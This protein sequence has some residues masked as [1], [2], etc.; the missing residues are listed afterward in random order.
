MVRF[1]MFIFLAISFIRTARIPYCLKDCEVNAI[2][3]KQSR[4]LQLLFTCFNYKESS[5]IA[6]PGY[7]KNNTLMK[8][9]HVT[10]EFKTISGDIYSFRP[11]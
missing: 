9:L 6:V 1:E 5:R 7:K 4:T 3:I 11:V 8:I 10:N 2:L